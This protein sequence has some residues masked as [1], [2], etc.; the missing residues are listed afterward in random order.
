MLNSLRILGLNHSAQKAGCRRRV[1]IK[2]AAHF[3]KDKQ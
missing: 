2:A 3:K 1:G